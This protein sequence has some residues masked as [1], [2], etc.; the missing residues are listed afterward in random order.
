[1]QKRRPRIW[2]VLAVAAL[3][4][5]VWP[6]VASFYTDWLWVQELGYQTIFSTT[7]LAKLLLG[8]MT[9]IVAA[10]LIW[11]NFKVAS[12]GSASITLH[13]G[14]EELK[15]EDVARL[16]GRLALPVSLLLGAFI[17]L[18]GWAAW[19]T[20][21][22][23]RYQA[24][25]GESDPIFQHDLAY[26]FFTLPVLELVSQLLLWL[27]G[28]CFVGAI[29]FYLLRGALTLTERGPSVARGARAHL[30]SLTAA[31]FLIL[32]WRAYLE[33]PGLLYSTTAPFFGASYSDINAALPMLK[34]T[35]VAAVLAAVLAAASI[36]RARNNLLYAG[37]GLYLLALLAGWI[38][39]ALVQ[40]FSVTPNE[41]AKESEYIAHN[42]AA[43]RK[44]FGLD[45]VEEHELPG[46]T[47]LSPK[48]IEE[49][50]RTINN[51]RLWD[52]KPLL[53]AFAQLQEFRTYYQFLSV[54][55]DRYKINGELRQIMLSARELTA[56]SLP[57]RNW[58]N[59][60]LTYTHGFGLTLG[61]VNQV[62]PE[63]LPVLF[64][65]DIPPA[66][67]VSTLNVTRPE[68]YF[69]EVSNDHV[70]VKTKAKEFA[71][72]AGE[73]V[74]ASYE[75]QGGVSIGSTWRQLL[76]ATRFGDKDLLLS[77]YVTPESR[78][79]YYRNIKQRLEMVAPFLHFDNDP[80][81]V[82]S[83]GRLFWI[84]DAYTMSDRYPYAQP[85][86]IGRDNVNYMRNSVKAVVDAYHGSVRLYIADERDPLIQT[87][88]RIFPGI[89][90]PLTE[91][92]PDLR[93]HLRYPEDLFRLQTA[94]YSTYHMAQPQVFYNKEDQWEIA[95][96]TGEKGEPQIMDPYY[97]IMKLPREQAEEFLLMLPFTPRDKSNLA[98]WMVARSDGEHYGHLLVYRFPKQKLVFGP[99]QIL[100]RINA[101]A[102]I[103][104]QLTLWNQ[105]GSKVIFGTLLVIPIKE[106]LIYVQPIYLLA[107]SG[108]GKIPEL[109]RVVVVAENKIAM[110]ETLEASLA[111][112][113]GNAP[114]PPQ[115]EE[116][117]AQGAKLSEAVP[118]AAP[119]TN[120]ASLAAQAKQHYDRAL[121]A[122]REG[123]WARYGDEIKRL[124][125]VLEQMAKQK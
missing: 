41:L 112:I 55:N 5:I 115:T 70:Y 24:P 42:I 77:D 107:E 87:Y 82:I 38:Y 80:Y 94:V 51:I 103:S 99:K 101:D 96:V 2:L 86:V 27:V 26:Y 124:G 13:L 16:S 64:I 56:E 11:I 40:R 104:P 49:N 18:R 25:F 36:F 76:F 66:S 17:A 61:P 120:A 125:A 58:I 69:G 85:W 105:R 97:T 35:V 123:D 62:N 60:R 63:G 46:D 92:S 9:G 54:D 88:K 71:Y 81:L 109:K 29:V 75:G 43:T 100:T 98:S 22:L 34:V 33:M 47:A 45:R 31:L 89:L 90:R 111:R 3:V 119:A 8:A 28:I 4:L 7:L 10:A 121:Q 14:S 23:F 32:A 91:M 53:E 116:V 84:C 15:I 44:A 72:P 57:S 67:S 73:D 6:T 30:L 95:S 65:K 93:A 113:F 37:F 68:I 114:P 108:K 12:R 78:V 110:E 59:E 122:Q 74:Y 48:D 83:E 39:P 106:S 19:E 52:Q 1:M 79:I 102:Q 117:L 50:R 20:V 21:L 118:N